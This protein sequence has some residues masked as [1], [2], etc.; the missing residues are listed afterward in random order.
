LKKYEEGVQTFAWLAERWPENRWYAYRLGVSLGLSGQYRKSLKVLQAVYDQ[1]PASAVVCAKIGLVYLQL[2]DT[3]QACQYFNETLML[4]QYEPT[5]LF[6][7][8]RIRAIQGNVD[9][10][11]VYLQRLQT[12]E[13]AEDQARELAR[14]LGKHY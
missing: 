12:I 4:D 13:G 3:E 9:R 7:L 6:H 8:A 1:K 2:N 5:A 10:A 11:M 14:L